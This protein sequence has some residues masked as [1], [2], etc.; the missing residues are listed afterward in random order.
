MNSYLSKLA[1]EYHENFQPIKP[2]HRGL[3]HEQLGIPEGEKIPTEKLE[4]IL[5]TSDDPKLRKR[6]QF[7]LNARKWKHAKKAEETFKMPMSEAISEHKKLVEVLKSNDRKKELEELEEQ[8][9]ELKEMLAKKAA[10]KA[11]QKT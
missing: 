3:L 1:S 2:S 7:A 8:G 10:L 6:V 11:L 5:A 4:H 9:D